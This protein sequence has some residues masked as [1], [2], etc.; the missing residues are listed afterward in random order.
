V[1]VVV[2]LV[3]VGLLGAAPSAH[4][5]GTTLPITG[6]S[7]MV[8]DGAHRHV[9]VSGDAQS[10][11]GVVVLD[12]DGRL[13]RT[14][15]H[16]PGADG[17]ALSG[18]DTVL[19]VGLATRQKIVAIDTA[20]LTRTTTYQLGAQSGCPDS[21]AMTAGRIWFTFTCGSEG[22]DGLAWLDPVTGIVT[23]DLEVFRYDALVAVSPGAPD[24]LVTGRL[25]VE[26]ITY[27]AFRI[28]AGGT[29]SHIGS[30]REG[31]SS[32][33]HDLAFTPDGSEALSAAT[34]PWNVQRYT[35]PALAPN[36]EYVTNEGSTAVAV[37]VTADGAYV[38]VAI[39]E[40]DRNLW[41]YPR[42]GGQW[43]HQYQV[44]VYTPE[45]PFLYARGLAFTPDRM[46][47]FGVSGDG[48]GLCQFFVIKHPTG[49][50]GRAA[51]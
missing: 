1:S 28:D 37:E 27:D 23:N 43:K 36:G 24:L 50:K 21:L 34:L 51:P 17:L 5:R 14:I 39:G 13:V 12:Y 49:R 38:A 46:R 42:A 8:V 2:V 26:P 4:A 3:A 48:K 11:S 47:L 16:L 15:H 35:V 40:D 19:F 33:L 29:P 32:D 45:A 6:F 7:N 20:T 30:Y 41:V 44:R 9:F 22:P 31:T 18:D 10:D 25:H